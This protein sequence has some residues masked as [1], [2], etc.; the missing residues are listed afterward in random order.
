MGSLFKYRPCNEFTEDIFT[1][2]CIHYSNRVAFNDPYDCLLCHDGAEQYTYLAQWV[3]TH[4]TLPLSID[5]KELLPMLQHEIDDLPICCFS[6][7]GS[8]MQMWSHYAEY[9]RG[10]C[11]EFDED[12]LLDRKCCEV[13]SVNYQPEQVRFDVT[14]IK[15]LTKETIKF[16]YT[17]HSSWA[18]EEEVRF[19][20]M[21]E[22]NSNNNYPFNKNALTAI[23]FGSKCSD[24]NIKLYINLCKQMVLNT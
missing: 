23:Y 15:N 21:P 17:K 5:I 9:H 18:Y 10:L 2:G 24:D 8:Q 20:H 16:L 3:D 1:S 12:L 14:N 6:K 11:L 22:P 13:H 7:N 19:F 4:I